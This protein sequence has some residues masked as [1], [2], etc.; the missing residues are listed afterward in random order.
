[1]ETQILPG[2]EVIFEHI[3]QVD[4]GMM[5]P[6]FKGRTFQKKYILSGYIDKIH[7]GGKYLIKTSVSCFFS[8]TALVV[9]EVPL[10]KILG[11]REKNNFFKKFNTYPQSTEGYNILADVH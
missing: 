5:S 2:N 9:P 4:M 3:E 8:K 11:V 7:E 1:M 6:E 10:S